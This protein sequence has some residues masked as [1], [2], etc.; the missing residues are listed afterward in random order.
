[1]T[2]YGVPDVLTPIYGSHP[3][4]AAI[5]IRLRPFSAKHH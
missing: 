5:F 2:T 3:I 4:G 1:M